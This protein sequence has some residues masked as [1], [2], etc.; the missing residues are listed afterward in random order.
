MACFSKQSAEEREQWAG[1]TRVPGL[2]MTSCLDETSGLGRDCIDS[3]SSYS[4]RGP[5][6]AA[7]AFAITASARSIAAR[8]SSLF[9]VSTE[10]PSSYDSSVASC[11][12]ETSSRSTAM[13]SESSLAFNSSREERV[14]SLES[15]HRNCEPSGNVVAINDYCVC[16]RNMTAERPFKLGFEKP[17]HRDS[18]RVGESGS[19][20]SDLACHSHM[21][22]LR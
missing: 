5:A 3:A 4:V 9:Q 14:T 2:H 20:C 7:A 8:K 6:V 19:R 21:G 11:A 1:T 15:P 13:A 17:V 10:W 22:E 18:R 12:R 16:L